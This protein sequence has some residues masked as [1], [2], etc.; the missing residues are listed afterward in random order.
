MNSMFSIIE[1]F[2]MPRRTTLLKLQ[3]FVLDVKSA[4]GGYFKRSVHM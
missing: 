2:I 3:T 1:L 4:Q